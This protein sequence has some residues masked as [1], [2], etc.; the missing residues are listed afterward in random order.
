MHIL[1]TYTTII[2]T[3]IYRPLRTHLIVLHSTYLSEGSEKSDLVLF[4]TPSLTNTL[5]EHRVACY[6]SGRY[7]LA[8]L[9]CSASKNL[10]KER[11]DVLA[12][13]VLPELFF[14]FQLPLQVKIVLG[15]CVGVE[16]SHWQCS[17]SALWNEKLMG[18]FDHIC[19]YQSLIYISIVL[20]HSM[21]AV[22]LFTFIFGGGHTP[23]YNEVL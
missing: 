5:E 8:H 19:M 15:M 1:F 22:L 12:G 7:G 18:S 10:W 20:C 4:N 11:D 16:N 9:W 21:T 14:F 23:R 13:R 6:V 3:P 17:P 2:Y